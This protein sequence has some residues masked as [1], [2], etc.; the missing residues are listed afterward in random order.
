MKKLTIVL[1]LLGVLLEALGIV[2]AFPKRFPFVLDLVA[3]DYQRA[4]LGLDSLSRRQEL[5]PRSP[6]FEEIEELY[7]AC[8]RDKNPPDVLKKIEITKITRTDIDSG[9]AFTPSGTRSFIPIEIHLSNGQKDKW[10]LEILRAKV[11][12]L[13]DFFWAI[14]VLWI[15]GITLQATSV[16]LEAR[17]NRKRTAQPTNPPDCQ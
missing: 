4:C 14:L 13:K 2:V 10:D 1:F 15:L 6:G 11:E 7:F 8:L 16:Y 9:L 3:S 5:T 17:S 12:D